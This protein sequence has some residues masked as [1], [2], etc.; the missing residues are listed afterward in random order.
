MQETR[1]WICLNLDSTK[2]PD[3]V[4]D[5]QYIPLASNSVDSVICMETME[6]VG[7]PRQVAHEFGR[8]LQPGG[9]LILS[10][11]FLYRIHSRPWDYWR[12]TEYGV[13]RLV[14][15]AGLE[16]FQLEPLGQL[17][18]VLCDMT[19]QVISEVRP[20]ILRWCLGILF[21]P[22]GAI[23]VSLE[24][25]GLGRRSPIWSSFTTGYAVLAMK[26]Q[27]EDLNEHSK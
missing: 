11:P 25:G 27:D 12:F 22:W 23:L 24:R 10:V 7:D 2:T 13:R 14:V 18:T 17:F 19:K 9:V 1:R 21:L 16:V 15:D 4:A 20:S 26:P 6:H 8:I 5:G 3:V